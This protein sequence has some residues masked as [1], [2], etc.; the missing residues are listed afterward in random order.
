MNWY[1][2]KPNFEYY[3]KVK[4][5]GIFPVLQYCIDRKKKKSTKYVLT[6]KDKVVTA[7][8]VFYPAPS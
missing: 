6:L 5:Y 8:I 3:L 1:K 4:P 2:R 7:D